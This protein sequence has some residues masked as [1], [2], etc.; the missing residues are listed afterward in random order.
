MRRA[1]RSIFPML[2]FGAIAVALSCAPP[3]TE[4]APA[5]APVA[6]PKKQAPRIA[7]HAL[8]KQIHERVNKE[9]RKRGLPTMRWDDALGRIAGRH[10]RDMSK[11]QYFGH[12]SPDGHG[13]S[14]RYLK[15]GHACGVTV[16]G[17]L[18]RGAENICRLSPGAEEDLV[19]A[20]MRGWLENKDDKKNLLSSP[21]DRE[22]TG[23]SIGPDGVIYV[24]M[25]FC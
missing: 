14:Y 25:N 8:E 15:S 9:R 1:A 10:S 4:A 21:W 13:Y 24:T 7:V 23:V 18:R 22:G 2:T 17:V 5:A 20:I 6:P 16:D 11:K 3:S 12:T 19:E